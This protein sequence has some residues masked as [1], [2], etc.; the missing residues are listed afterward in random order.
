MKTFKHYLNEANYTI[1]E[2]D[3][4]TSIHGLENYNIKEE[5]VVGWFSNKYNPA[6]GWVLTKLTPFEQKEFNPKNVKGIF[7]SYT[8]KGTSIVKVDAKTGKY[9]FLD[10]EKYENDSKIKFERMAK[11]KVFM[12]DYGK[13]QFFM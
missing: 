7:R 10:N 5:D 12:I 13:E 6:A 3:R 9:S 11:A 1:R 2:K 4:S 8:D